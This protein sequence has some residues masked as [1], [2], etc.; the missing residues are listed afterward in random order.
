M[1]VSKRR[2][3][4]RK[5][6]LQSVVSYMLLAIFG[7]VIVYG[8][9]KWI[10][11]NRGHRA[12]LDGNCN[13]AIRIFKRVIPGPRFLDP[14]RFS[15]LAQ[16]ERDECLIY[17]QALDLQRIGNYR[18][19]LVAYLDFLESHPESGLTEAIRTHTTALFTEAEPLNLA[20]EIICRNTPFLLEKRLIPQR[21]INLPWF[22]LGCAHFY[23]YSNQTEQAYSAYVTFLKEYPEHEGSHDAEI[24]LINNPLSCQKPN[25]FRDSPIAD[26]TDFMP[27]L[28]YTCGLDFESTSEL[29]DAIQMFSTFLEEYP[30]HRFAGQMEEALART[31]VAKAESWE[32]EQLPPPSISGRATA[33]DVT[34]LI[35]NN[36]PFEVRIAF[37]GSQALVDDLDVCKNCQTYKVS[38]PVSCSSQNP[39]K[40]FK[41]P[42]GNYKVAIEVMTQEG[43]SYWLG[44]WELQE[45]KAYRSCFS[46]VENP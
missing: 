39:A 41:L 40:Q 22:N 3:T 14:A 36:S 20:N 17:Q 25:L 10:S 44:I 42:P 11:F 4:R 13:E 16:I 29:D 5:I 1:P 46:V 12:F 43:K 24:G 8:L 33:G 15:V 23:D 19:A 6:T 2:I 45:G 30:D 38:A 9:F 18:D 34:V 28:F 21:E 26:R 7:L 31:L 27:K 37:N 35:L 32:A